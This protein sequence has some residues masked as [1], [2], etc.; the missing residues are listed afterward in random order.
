MSLPDTGM[1][2]RM[3]GAVLDSRELSGRRY[4][5]HRL[6]LIALADR[7]DDIGFCWPSVDDIARRSGVARGHISRIVKELEEL[8]WLE[9]ER[10]P[11]GGRGL[12]NRYYVTPK[13]PADGEVINAQNLPVTRAETS[14]NSEKPPRNSTKT[15]HRRGANRQEPSDLE[16]SYKPSSSRFASKKS[17]SLKELEKFR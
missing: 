8:G 7:A 16:P 1:S 14:H 15:S 4:H 13:D 12:S 9:V 11:G 2:I 6:V 17:D 5:A 10:F 3:V